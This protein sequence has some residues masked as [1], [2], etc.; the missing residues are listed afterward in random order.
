M[1]KKSNN[2]LGA[3]NNIS[4]MKYLSEKDPQG[5]GNIATPKLIQWKTAEMCGNKPF[6]GFC[7]FIFC[8]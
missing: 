8:F 3:K 2:P 5:Q 7:G 1:V 4:H 6:H